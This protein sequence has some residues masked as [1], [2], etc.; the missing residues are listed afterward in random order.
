M[1]SKSLLF[2]L[3][4]RIWQALGGLLT[5]FFIAHILSPNQQGWFY[6][7]ISIASLYTLFEMGLSIALTQ[8]TAH[9]FIKLRWLPKGRVAGQNTEIFK[10]FFA[11]SV[12]MYIKFA[13]IFL[14]L[15]FVIG[16]FIFNQKG[17]L[18]VEGR[19]WLWP[20]IA[21]LVGT[22]L[23]MAML[24]FFAVVEGSG[25]VTEVYAI[26]L[27]QGLV[28]SFAC[29][30]VLS[31]GGDLW[32]A[33]MFPILGAIIS[34]IWF[35]KKRPWLFKVIFSENPMNHF[36]WTEEVWPLQ[37]RI[38]ISWI[39]LFLMTQL[40]VP[41]LF[42]YKN[43][44]LAGQ[45]GLSLTIAHM[46]GILSQS[47]ITRHIPIMSQA[48]A[49]KEWHILD[50]LFKKDFVS[51]MGVFIFGAMAMLI[52]Q[53]FLAQSSY[54]NRTLDFWP[55]FGLLVFAFFYYINGALAIHMRS[56][57]KEP[58]FYVSFLGGFIILLGTLITAKYF[59]IR[60]VIWLMLA[61]QIFLISPITIIIWRLR[62]KEYRLG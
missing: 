36:N 24:P 38:A 44:I 58:F 5:I 17:G 45:M 42:H 51:S 31:S 28:G 9:L 18:I 43:P 27:T 32:A 59:S 22:A 62:N 19:F 7:F 12:K 35:F 30:F 61:T 25:Q 60:E 39:S 1:V 37:W 54:A 15:A 33:S 20:W 23:N 6:T 47:W 11:S 3:M 2:I 55:F 52:V 10:A 29:W 4:Q 14:A 41:I 50:G 40:S 48:V 57:K 53:A 8:V 16:Y 26:R 56:F 21:L 49:K 46:I 34:F 13:F